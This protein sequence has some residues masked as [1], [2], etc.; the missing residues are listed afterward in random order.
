[1]YGA[2]IVHPASE[3]Y[4]GRD[5]DFK[6]MVLGEHPTW[7]TSDDIVMDGIRAN[8]SVGI[9]QED[10]IYF[11]HLRDAKYAKHLNREAKDGGGRPRLCC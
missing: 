11:D 1:M 8:D 3:N 6:K 10:C 7:W 2:K 5:A 4:H 9:L